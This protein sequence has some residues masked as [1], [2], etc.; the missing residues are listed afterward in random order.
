MEADA[1]EDIVSRRTK[2]NNSI[3]LLIESDLHSSNSIQNLLI[4]IYSTC[5][6]LVPRN[7]VEIIDIN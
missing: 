4:I 3:V 5:V 6:K 7:I 2:F 1:K